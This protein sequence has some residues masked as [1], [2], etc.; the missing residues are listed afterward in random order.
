MAA[1]Y[2]GSTA[3]LAGIA[4]L[5]F[6]TR[7]VTRVTTV[8]SAEVTR[9]LDDNPR[10]LSWFLCNRGRDDVAARFESTAVGSYG[11]LI[12]PNGGV[13]SMS[14]EEDG[15]SVTYA[16]YAQSLDRD[17]PLYVIEVITE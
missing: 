6:P 11:F 10:R 5:G 3:Y 2:D 7:L 15:E 14:I 9:I 13:V 8:T 16:V 12:T 4:R 1:R 17:C